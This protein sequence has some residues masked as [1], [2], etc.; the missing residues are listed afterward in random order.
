MCGWT[1]ATRPETMYL[2]PVRDIV[3]LAAAFVA[4]RRVA[5]ANPYGYNHKH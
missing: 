4:E 1:W 3:Q 5:L 2:V